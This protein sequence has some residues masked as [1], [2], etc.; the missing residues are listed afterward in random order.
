MAEPAEEKQMIKNTGFDPDGIGARRL[1]QEFEHNR[2][3]TKRTKEKP[4][5]ER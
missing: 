3:R 1:C 2:V 5:R 4:S